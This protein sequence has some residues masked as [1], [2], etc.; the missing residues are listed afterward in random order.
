MRKECAQSA[1]RMNVRC[2]CH[3]QVRDFRNDVILAE[4]CRGDVETYC[5]AVPAGEPIPTTQSSMCTD[6]RMGHE[7]K[8]VAQ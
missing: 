2:W 6:R 7:G 5:K 4:A 1:A 3:A 8:N